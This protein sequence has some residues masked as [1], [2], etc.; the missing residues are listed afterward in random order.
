MIRG[1]VAAV[2]AAVAL[3]TSAVAQSA[4]SVIAAAT[5]KMSVDPMES[6]TFNGTARNGS[7]GQS[8]DIENPMG[9]VNATRI[10][11]YRRTI[12]FAQ[13]T[14]AGQFVSR[15]TG[16]MQP[17][18][19]PGVP[20]QP[21]APFNQNISG[22]QASSS[23]AQALNV[24]LTPWGFLKAAAANNAT[25][26][27]EGGLKVVSFSPANFR[28]PSGR[29]YTVTGYINAQNLVTKVET[30][31]EH[32]V[33]GD[34]P[35]EFE[36][37]SYRNF[38]GV[39]TP[40]RIV[41]R[42]AGMTTFEAN[43]TNAMA[44]PRDLAS[45][46]AAPTPAPAAQPAPGAGAAQPPAAPPVEQIAPGVFKIGGNY[47]SL[48]IDLGSEILIIESGQNEARGLA[49]V[50]AA[51]QALP[52][53]MIRFVVNSH[54]HFDHA[55]GLPAAVAAGATILTHENNANPLNRF[56]TG[57]RTLLGDSLSRVADR[58]REIVKGINDRTV[59]R[60]NAAVNFRRV[61]VLRVPNEHSDGMLAV[62]L[63]AEKILWTADITIVN[64][65]PVQLGVVRS[66][67]EAFDRFKVDYDTWIPA[68]PA[69]PDRPLTR[70]DV[71][72]AVGR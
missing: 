24:W 69:T 31:V 49:V 46:L 64:P 57:P 58:S 2:L 18:T 41:Q 8:K 10:L 34:L 62:W 16:R 9:D 56:L 59:F 30:V 22:Q 13:A 67:V 11:D 44:N 35:V 42:Q 48:A 61:E 33:V 37:F 40:M 54:P 7:F 71:Q 3:S 51:Q 47:T 36:F 28:S 70:A 6:V 39:Q 4:S 63:P 20:A 45:L 14:A 50:Q 15:A 26:R 29:S 23:W 21:E 60:G 55:G 72:A 1:S 38:N 17:P 27:E 32:P 52:N 25:L 53:K 65:T 5:A 68:H 43:I 66:A 19:V 12:S